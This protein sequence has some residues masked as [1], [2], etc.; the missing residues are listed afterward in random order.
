MFLFLLLF[1]GNTSEE[2]VYCDRV[3]HESFYRI[4]D[5]EK[6]QYKELLFYEQDPSNRAWYVRNYYMLNDEYPNQSMFYIYR[7]DKDY[8]VFTLKRD[9]GKII[10]KTKIYLEVITVAEQD[11]EVQNKKIIEEKDRNRIW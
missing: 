7:K 6:L 11:L 2:I 5:P 1:I 9:N 10:I 4:S 8:H 3:I